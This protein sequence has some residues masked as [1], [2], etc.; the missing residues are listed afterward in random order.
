MLKMERTTVRRSLH[1]MVRH[2]SQVCSSFAQHLLRPRV[3]GSWQLSPTICQLKM[4]SLAAKPIT[5][6]TIVSPK[7]TA[8]PNAHSGAISILPGVE[9][10]RRT[11]ATTTS[12][13]RT[14]RNSAASAGNSFLKFGSTAAYLFDVLMPPGACIGLT[15]SGPNKSAIAWEKG[16]D[17]A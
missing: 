1:R 15:R 11:I 12:G 16:N 5:N 10:R 7:R 4:C 13:N 6:F 14:N 9:S 17:S 3:Q 2:F 8:A